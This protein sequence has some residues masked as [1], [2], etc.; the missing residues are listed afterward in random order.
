MVDRRGATPQDIFN[1]PEWSQTHSHRVGLRD[2]NDRFPGI[3]HAGDDWRFEIE[4]EAEAKMGELRE[5]VSKGSLLTVRDFMNKQE[6]GDWC[7]LFKA[8]SL[9]ID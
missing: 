8:L 9:L 1:E 3:T 7:G 2:K 6:V 4:Q 5:M